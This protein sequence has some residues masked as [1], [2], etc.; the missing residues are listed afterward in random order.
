[1]TDIQDDKLPYV[2]CAAFCEL[3]SKVLMLLDE[4]NDP[5]EGRDNARGERRCGNQVLAQPVGRLQ[6]REDLIQ[7]T[8]RIVRAD[9]GLEI[10]I[11][12]MLDPYVWLMTNGYS[13]IRFC[14]IAQVVGG[15]LTG[16]GSCKPT[17]YSQGELREHEGLLRN[18]ATVRAVSDYISGV[19]HPLDRVQTFRCW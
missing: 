4:G 5:S 1:M 17:W 11:H 19:R 18:P 9:T 10:S 12:S 15:R 16:Q 2:A 3:D 13:I 7:A 8:A 6:P 14:F